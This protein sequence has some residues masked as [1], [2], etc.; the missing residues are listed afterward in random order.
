MAE[1]LESWARWRP[2]AEGDW[3][4]QEDA[5]AISH[6][7]K[8]PGVVR[9]DSWA[10]CVRDYD[11][12]DN[13]TRVHLRLVP[14][15]Y[16]GDL[17][18]AR[19]VILMLNPGLSATDYYAEREVPSFK[20]TVLANLHQDF[21]NT[22]YP[23]FALDPQF[24]WHSG[25][26][27]WQEKLGS[28]ITTMARHWDCR[29]Y[30]ARRRVSRRIAALELFPYHSTSSGISARRRSRMHSVKLS[31]E[32]AH[33]LAAQATNGARKVLVVVT[34]QHDQWGLDLDGVNVIEAPR[35]HAR[36]A[37]IGVKG[38]GIG[39]DVVAAL[40]DDS[41]YWSANPN[42]GERAGQRA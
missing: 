27:Y 4:L 12:W 8:A 35:K 28:I 33:R 9:Y 39:K 1:L 32:Y 29:P 2:P 14:L 10:D 17:T 37:Y 38:D 31:M 6:L 22:A 30:E 3:I 26:V 16:M 41:S 25:N 21:S 23:F 24:A 42:W 18:R 19:V 7:E 13:K 36:G 40:Q 34:R 15:P 5:P 11:P 20:E